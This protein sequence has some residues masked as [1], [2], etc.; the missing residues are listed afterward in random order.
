MKG[1]GGP[2]GAGLWQGQLPH[3]F[4]SAPEPIKTFQDRRGGAEWKTT[5][6]RSRASRLG[7]GVLGS[8][9]ILP[10]IHVPFLSQSPAWLAWPVRAGWLGPSGDSQD[11]GFHPPLR[12]EA[13]AGRGP[14]QG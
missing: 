10:F 12:G 7:R 5:A 14:A 13:P 8:L 9:W 2:V 4:L 11:A 3:A 1:L 6:R